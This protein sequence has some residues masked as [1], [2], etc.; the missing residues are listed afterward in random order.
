MFASTI[1]FL[2]WAPREWHKRFGYIAYFAGIYLLVEAFMY[3]SGAISYLKWRFW[4]SYILMIAGLSFVL[5]L[6]DKVIGN[7]SPVVE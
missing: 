1:I 6:S 7:Y 3:Q 2:N 5:Y 4:Y